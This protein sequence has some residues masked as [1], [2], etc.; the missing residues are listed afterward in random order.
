MRNYLQNA[1]QGISMLLANGEAL[2][3][4]DV[5]RQIDDLEEELSRINRRLIVYREVIEH[6]ENLCPVSSSGI[7]DAPMDPNGEANAACISIE[8]VVRESLL[9]SL[10]E[11]LARTE[12]DAENPHY[13]EPLRTLYQE[14]VHNAEELINTMQRLR[15]EIS[16]HDAD[17]EEPLPGRFKSA[18]ELI[19]ALRA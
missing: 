4:L 19:A 7:S 9:P 6:A 16:E 5:H 11:R 14:A 10:S 2:P 13:W 3:P 18:E 12:Q 8:G 17:L 15:W 1:T